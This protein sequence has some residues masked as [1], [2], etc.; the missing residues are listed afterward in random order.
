MGQFGVQSRKD[1]PFWWKTRKHYE[2]SQKQVILPNLELHFGKNLK[3]SRSPSPL[4]KIGEKSKSP[5]TAKNSFEV[6]GTPL[7]TFLRGLW[8]PLSSKI[9]DIHWKMGKTAKNKLFWHPEIHFWGNLEMSRHPLPPPK[10]EKI[11]NCQES[12]EIRQSC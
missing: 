8:T 3:M 5:K 9:A 1:G 12:I 11:R 6:I 7:E 2:S 10:S 4:N